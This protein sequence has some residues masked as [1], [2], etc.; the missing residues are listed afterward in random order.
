[1]PCARILPQA[2]TFT[3]PVVVFFV[4]HALCK[5]ITHSA[6]VLI[7][8]SS[9]YPMCTALLLSTTHVP[10]HYSSDL[11][12][13]TESVPSGLLFFCC[14]F[15]GGVWLEGFVFCP[16]SPRSPSPSCWTMSTLWWERRWS[17][18]WKCQRKEP[19]SSG[20]IVWFVMWFI[21]ILLT[22]E[23]CTLVI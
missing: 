7:P 4:F 18:R 8:S 10:G 16:Q 11:H 17:S 22:W 20:K 12:N 3:V 14:F 9:V 19:T 2:Q 23:R 13:T 21:H 6:W 15:S 5:H 1:M